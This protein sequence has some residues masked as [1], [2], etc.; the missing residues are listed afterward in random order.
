M[1]IEHHDHEE[2]LLAVEEQH[3]AK[4]IGDRE[5]NSLTEWIIG[6][7]VNRHKDDNK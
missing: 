3:A 5:R 2:A 1:C 7:F 4:A 6:N